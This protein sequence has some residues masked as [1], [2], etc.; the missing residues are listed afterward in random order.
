MG[1]FAIIA[2]GITDQLVLKNVLIGLC[3]TD[4]DEPV[5][6][7]EQPPDR[8]SRLSRLSHHGSHAPGG[9]DLVRRYLRDGRYKQALQTNRYLVIH[10]DTD[11]SEDYGVPKGDAGAE[12][13]LITRVVA[14]F[15]RFIDE[16]IWAVHGERFIFAIAVHAIECWLLPALFD[17]QKAKMAKLAGCFSAAD[18]QLQR[19]K[20]PALRRMDGPDGKNPDGYF[21][22]SLDYQK[23]RTLLRLCDANLSL[24]VFVRE[25]ERR[26]IRIPGEPA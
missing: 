9:W 25:V 12:G 16:E 4:E 22:A 7:F 20:R 10:I 6:N 2:E 19:L 17:T 13:D 14:E 8:L 15:R 5:I 1:D 24:G 23:R 21:R 11:V 26:N 18:E 3:S